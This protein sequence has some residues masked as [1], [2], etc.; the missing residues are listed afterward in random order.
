MSDVMDCTGMDCT[1]G[2]G[3]EIDDRLAE[4]LDALR[5]KVLAELAV[6]ADNQAE[7]V[8]MFSKTRLRTVVHETM[9]SSVEPDFWRL[10]L[11]S[12][13]TQEDADDLTVEELIVV[14]MSWIH[15]AAVWEFNCSVNQNIHTAVLPIPGP[16]SEWGEE[17]GRTPDVTLGPWVADNLA[18]PGSPEP[19]STTLLAASMQCMGL[20]CLTMTEVDPWSP[21]QPD[22]RREATYRSDV[23][24]TMLFPSGSLPALGTGYEEDQATTSLWMGLALSPSPVARGGDLTPSGTR[25][26][27][28]FPPLPAVEVLSPSRTATSSRR[29]GVMQTPVSP[30]ATSIRRRQLISPMPMPTGELEDCGSPP[31][32]FTRSAILH[33]PY[34]PASDTESPGG[35]VLLGRST[36][37]SEVKKAMGRTAMPWQG[38][39]VKLHIYDVS[40]LECI[41]RLNQ[42][43]AHQLSPLKFGGIFHAGVE[44]NG[45]EWSFGYSDDPEIPGVGGTA[46][47]QHEFHRFRQ[48]LILPCTQLSTEEIEKI[49]EK[50]LEEYPGPDYDLL[51]RN[52]C[53]FAD[54]LS[55]RLGCGPIPR[56][57][58]RLALIG[59]KIDSMLQAMRKVS[60]PRIRNTSTTRALGN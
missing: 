51:R 32:R 16:P 7:E 3:M 2:A 29:A 39:P 53:H 58:Y 31:C 54:D 21:E 25:D 18:S 43:L 9:A 57:V 36:V 26:A 8:Q 46:P 55:R 23:S 41:R 19:Q 48:T 56:W 28:G 45:K 59:A 12:I 1:D 11:S 5:E 17:F 27:R 22:V 34:T 15:D 37:D 44:V 35:T 13:D 33:M 60:L 47:R 10:A 24:R 14:M 20:G 6:Y 30:A 50:L 40:R 42:A 4:E 49:L 38:T 52:C